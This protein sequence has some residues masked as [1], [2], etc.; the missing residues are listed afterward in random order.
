MESKYHPQVLALMF[1][2]HSMTWASK[3]MKKRRKV[4]PLLQTLVVALEFLRPLLSSIFLHLASE[5][6]PTIH[7]PVLISSDGLFPS[8]YR[9]GQ[10]Y[11]FGRN[12]SNSNGQRIPAII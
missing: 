2:H 7:G 12:S 8:L 10:C 11:V 5:G 9:E 1:L 6:N 4:E 3:K